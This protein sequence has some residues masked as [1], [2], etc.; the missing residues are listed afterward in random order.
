MVQTLIQLVEQSVG[1][2]GPRSALLIK[3]GA[4]YERWTYTGLWEFAGKVAC[5]LQQRGLQKGD[6]VLL[7]GPNCPQWVLAFLGC[8]RT[9]IIPVPLSLGATGDFVERVIR[10]T[11][12]AL[13]VLSRDMPSPQQEL[14]V[15]SVYFEEL[16]ELARSLPAPLET[17]V[18]EED[19]AEIVFTSGTT[20]DPKGVMLTQANLMANLEAINQ[21]I[22]G[23]PSYRLLS[24]LPLSHMLEQ[25]SGLFMVLRCGA[26]VTYTR[27]H[28]FSTLLEILRERKVTTILMVPQTLDLFMKGIEREVRRQGKERL[29]Q[30]M[31]SLARYVP[32]PLRRRLFSQI[33]KRLGGCLEF[34]VCGGAA[35][36][37]ELGEKWELLGVKVIQGYGHTETSPVVSCDTLGNRRFDSVGR[38]LPGVEVRVSEDG[39]ILVR[40]PNVMPGY[41]EAP[42]LT[43]TAIQDGWLKTGDVGF[44]DEEG[45]LHLKGRKKDVIVLPNGQNVFPEDIE[46]VLRKHPAVIDATVVGL[47][48]GSRVEVHAALLLKDQAASEVVSWTNR[49]LADYQ[50]IRGFTLWPQED[51]P[52][53]HTLK[54]RKGVVLDVLTGAAPSGQVP[55]TLLSGAAAEEA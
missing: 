25:M 7:W 46:A 45:Y 4:S 42:E 14:E 24:L 5:L 33:H 48:K 15:P 34:I 16:E 44:I 38:P 39:E 51:F 2:F 9:G 47:P 50:R 36:D 17:E 35:L 52:R 27:S 53:T 29:W 10:Q 26:S 20:G 6:R 31:L 54:I 28:Q 22:P 19:L 13:A 30:R 8:M 1:R 40:G 43:A 37:P 21:Y 55:P 3:A 41:W 11:R 32:F 18:A 49:Q 23:K 12:P